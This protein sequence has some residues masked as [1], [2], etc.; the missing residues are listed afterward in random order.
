MWIFFRAFAAE[1][2]DPFFEVRMALAIVRSFYTSTRFELKPD[3]SK[4]MFLSAHFLM[5][6]LVS[7]RKPWDEFTMPGKVLF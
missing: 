7:H 5:E 2:D 1:I 3:F 4:C 6:T